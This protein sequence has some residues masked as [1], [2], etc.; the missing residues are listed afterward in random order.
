VNIG[1]R[2]ESVSEQRGTDLGASTTGQTNED[3][4]RSGLFDPPVRLGLHSEPFTREPFGEDVDLRRDAPR[5]ERLGGLSERCLD[6][7]TL[8]D[9]VELFGETLARSSQPHRKC[10]LCKPLKV[11]STHPAEPI[12]VNTDESMRYRLGV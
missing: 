1:G 8:V 5:A 7:R 6:S 3:D 4:L 10:V 9:A 11:S 12:V 2:P